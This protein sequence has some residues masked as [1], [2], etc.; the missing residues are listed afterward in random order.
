MPELPTRQLEAVEVIRKFTLEYGYP[1]CVREMAQIM[2]VT[3][4][5]VRQ[6]LE[7]LERKGAIRRTPG[8]SRSVVLVEHTAPTT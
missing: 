5:A 8:T 7:S 6:Y 4:T 2:R 1:P 3:P